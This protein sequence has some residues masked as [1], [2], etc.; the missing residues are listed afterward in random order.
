MKYYSKTTMQKWTKQVLI[1]HIECLQ[2]NLQNE[3]NLNDHMYKT[4]MT[5]GKKDPA[6]SN[7]VGEVLEVWNK[8]GGTRYEEE[9]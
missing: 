6:F 9:E 8:Y 7:A 2:H 5:V 4:I 1:E 3:Q